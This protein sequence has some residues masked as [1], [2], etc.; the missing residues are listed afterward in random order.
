M[1]KFKKIANQELLKEL[2][3]RL[4]DF[5]QDEFVTLTR[6]LGK[7]QQELMK[8]FQVISPQAHQWIQT[9]IQEHEK[10][11]TDK[12]VEELKKKLTKK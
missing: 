9:K 4:P 12:K 2:E 3:Q 10:E 8:V 5:T 1:N 6:L 11:E 7:Y